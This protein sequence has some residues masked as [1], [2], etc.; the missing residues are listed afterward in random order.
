MSVERVQQAYTSVAELYIE[1]FGTAGK[2]HPDDLALVARHLGN[3][4]GPVLDLG[5]GPGH[6]TDYLRGLGT[7]ATGVDVVPEFIAHA[8]ATHPTGTYRLG[9][10]DDLAIAEHSLAGILAW[11]S[12]IHRPPR[13]F[14]AVLAGF[15]RAMAPGGS[16]VLGFFVGDEVDAFEHKVVT[17]YR[18]P[19]DEVAARLARAGFTEVERLLRL[20]DEVHRPHAAIAAVA[21]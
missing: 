12:L 19:P 16:L 18:W 6:L 13:E 10:M 4:P 2:V 11:Y 3:R 20:D 21:R 17:A 5:C 1:L 14:D 9:S 8:R 7:D 15:R